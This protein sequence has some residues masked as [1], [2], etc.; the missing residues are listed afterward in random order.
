MTGEQFKPGD[1]VKL[2]SGGPDMTVSSGRTSGAG[3]YV[4]CEWFDG[5][6]PKWQEFKQEALKLAAD[7]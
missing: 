1:V 7:D 2:R 5:T 6:T 3:A 4:T